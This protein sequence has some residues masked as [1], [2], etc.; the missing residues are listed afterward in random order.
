MHKRLLNF[1]NMF[2][3][4]SDRQ[5]GFIP[6]RN[7]DLAIFDTV[8]TIT[9]A[10]NRNELVMGICLDLSKAF[11]CVNHDLLLNKLYYHGIRGISLQ[12]LK[13]YLENRSQRVIMKTS[14]S[15]KRTIT[16][17]VPQGSV[18]GPLLFILYINDL[19]MIAS[20]NITLFADDTNFIIAAKTE[21]S[22]ISSV[23][24]TFE[25][26]LGWFNDNGLKMNVGKTQIINFTRDRNRHEID[27]TLQ[28][29]R[30]QTV[31]SVKFLGV[32][33]D[34]ELNWRQHITQLR[35]KLAKNIYLLRNLSRL[36]SIETVIT[37]YYGCVYSVLK[38][39]VMFWGYSTDSVIIFRLQKRCLRA[40]FNL[41]KTTSCSDYFQQHKIL[42]LPSLYIYQTAIFVKQY[43]TM[44]FKNVGDVHDHDTRQTRDLYTLQTTKTFLGKNAYHMAIKIYNQAVP[45]ELK[46]LPLL[47]FKKMLKTH[48]IQKN[49][50]SFDSIL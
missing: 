31:N 29:N 49:Y 26:A 5:N 37:A 14:M 6:G 39:G 10:L 32:Y 47:K 13:S 27:I 7:T 23:I 41:R 24:S 2:H 9:E 18:L 45:K 20:S 42:T 22:T 12:W 46:G 8:K 16:C 1:L 50:Y 35:S 11:D 21:K 40:M 34:S 33:L 15:D 4:L 28:G 17:G 3:L 30:I 19:P 48:L 43:G 38:Y 25:R 36:S 44:F